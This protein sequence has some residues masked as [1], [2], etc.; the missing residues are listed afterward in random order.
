MKRLITLIVNGENH[1]V[2]VEPGT[3]LLDVLRG[4]LGLTGTKLACDYGNCGSCTVLI[5]G[6]AVL[7]CLTL[8]IDAQGKDIITVEGLAQNGRLHPL[9]Q[10]FV[11]HGAIQCGFCTPGMLLS[12]K[13][14][15]D[16]NPHPDEAEVKEAISG[17]LC[18]CT[19]YHKIVDAILD[20]AEG[21]KQRGER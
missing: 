15:L 17:N 18:R 8:A 14:L 3:I 10:S 7:S 16:Q 19:G 5:D 21:G 11:E 6:K 9:Q 13:A 4:E 20:V 2:A 1:E 12:A